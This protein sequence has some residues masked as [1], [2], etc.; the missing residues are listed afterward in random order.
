MTTGTEIAATD[1][2]DDDPG[3]RV[4]QQACCWKQ[5]HLW[6]FW[7]REVLPRREY[8][9]PGIPCTCGCAQLPNLRRG[10]S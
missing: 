8:W 6:H 2:V 1:E 9:C 5:S 10:K 4:L 3:Y 7:T